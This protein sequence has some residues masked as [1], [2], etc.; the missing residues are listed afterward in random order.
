VPYLGQI[1]RRYGPDGRDAGRAVRSLE[2]VLKPFLAAL[3]ASVLTLAV[4]ESVS[5]PVTEPVYPNHVLRGLGLLSFIPA[6]AGGLD[7][8]L[9]RSAAFAVAD[10]QLC[11]VYLNDPAHTATVAATFSG[12]HSDGIATVACG[13]HRAALGMD[14]PRAGDVILVASPDRWFAPDW[15]NSRSEKPARVDEG[16]GI[17]GV[18]AGLDPSYIH[19]SLGAPPPNEDYLGVVVT[20]DAS[21]LQ[22]AQQVS[23]RDLSR[24]LASPLGL[25]GR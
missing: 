8:D 22:G 25:S 3:P 1:A 23:A 14:H 13:S 16:S 12:P 11:H 7:I 21:I 6:T 9:Q 20:S 15:W 5:T 17:A 24:L 4:T 10:H 19:G 2:A 18:G